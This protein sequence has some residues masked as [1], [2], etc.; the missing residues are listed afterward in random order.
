MN[1]Q[2]IHD[3]PWC[4]VFNHI[5]SNHLDWKYHLQV[6]PSCISDPASASSIP[7]LESSLHLSSHLFSPLHCMSVILFLQVMSVRVF[8]SFQPPF[9]NVDVRACCF[10]IANFSFPFFL[11][12][13]FTHNPPMAHMHSPCH[14]SYCHPYFFISVQNDSLGSD[15]KKNFFKNPRKAARGR[16]KKSTR[17][18]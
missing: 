4:Q 8:R 7:G 13:P 10:K 15:K 11:T 6:H 17:K 2:G 5:W 14:L 18:R 1:G 12:L 3:D 16:E 9:G